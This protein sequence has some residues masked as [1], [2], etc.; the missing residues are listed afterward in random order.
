[1]CVNKED[2][3]PQAVYLSGCPCHSCDYTKARPWSLPPASLPRA[4]RARLSLTYVL[5]FCS[6]E[7]FIIFV[8]VAMFSVS[9]FTL[10]LSL[11][12]FGAEESLK[13]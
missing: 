5:Q 7:T 8:S 2:A 11:H 13:A 12:I 10:Y 3:L 4:L 6:T 9:L 1:M